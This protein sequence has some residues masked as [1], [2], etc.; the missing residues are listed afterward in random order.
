MRGRTATEAGPLIEVSGLVQTFGSARAPDGSTWM[1][2]EAR[3]AATS[4]PSAPTGGW[5]TT[6]HHSPTDNCERRTR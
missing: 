5:H 3:C 4:V 2:P 1:S 6:T